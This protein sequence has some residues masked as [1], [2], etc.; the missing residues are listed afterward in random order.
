MAKPKNDPPRKDPP[1][2]K[3]K[4]NDDPNIAPGKDNQPPV[5]KKDEW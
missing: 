1:I 5:R 4:R 2:R 3:E